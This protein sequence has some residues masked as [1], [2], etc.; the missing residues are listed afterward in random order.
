ME[1]KLIAPRYKILSDE[2]IDKINSASF[3][4]L[5]NIGVRITN[6]KVW[7]HLLEFGAEI[8]KEKSIVKC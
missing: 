4:I 2:S 7:P 6:K 8:D 5:K 3:D 1:N